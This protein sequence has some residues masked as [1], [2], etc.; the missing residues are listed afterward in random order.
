MKESTNALDLRR[1]KSLNQRY[2]HA[3]TTRYRRHPP[4]VNPF[5]LRP[6]RGSRTDPRLASQLRVTVSGLAALSVYG[7]YGM[8]ATHQATMK[9]SDE[10]WK[11]HLAV[12]PVPTLRFATPIHAR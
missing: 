8:W 2:G 12:R 9:A 6:I 10:A 1:L 4:Q 7:M 3:S 11:K 5:T